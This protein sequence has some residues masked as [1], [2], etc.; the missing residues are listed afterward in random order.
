MRN[1]RR[2]GALLLALVVAVGIL[3]MPVQAVSSV[4]DG[5][6]L[7]LVPDQT[8][9]E[10]GQTITATLT[11]CNN[12]DTPMEG[13]CLQALI[14]QGYEAAEE[15][16]TE[17]GTLQPGEQVSI[18]LTFDPEQLPKMG[19]PTF[20]WALVLTAAAVLLALVLRKGRRGVCVLLA[21]VMT[22]GL[23]PAPA[24]AVGNSKTLS[25]RANVT[26]DGKGLPLEAQV[27]YQPLEAQLDPDGD[28][29][30]TYL[31]ELAKTDPQLADTDGD[32]VTDHQELC[33]IGTDPLVVDSDGDGTPDGQEDA[34][35]DLLDNAREHQLGTQPDRPDT[36]GDGITDG[37]E[38][39]RCHTDPLRADTD[40]DA[41]DDGQEQA[42]GSDPLVPEASFRVTQTASD[43]K[44]FVDM[45]LTGAQVGTLK[46]EDAATSPLIPAEFPGYLGK[47]YDFTVDGDFRQAQISFCFNE[48]V[49]ERGAKPTIYYVDQ[50]DQVLQP[51]A[52]TVE[53]GVAT[54]TVEHFSTYV[55]L[56]STVY[57]GSFTWEDTWDNTGT[58][59]SVEVVLVVDDSGSM[60]YAGDYLDPE[61]KRLQV[62]RDLID[63][64]PEGAKIG[65]VWFA[66]SA[67]L[68]TPTLTTDKEEAKAW[69]TT[70]YFTSIG[71]STNMY[72]A[73]D[74]SLELFQST[75]ADALKTAIVLTDGRAHDHDDHHESTIAAAQ[76]AGVQV[77]TVGLGDE[78][79]CILDHLQPLSDSTGG[80]FHYAEHAD[81]LSEIYADISKMI[82]L[83]V[84]TDGDTIPDYYEDNMVTF[85]GI[86]V[87]LD[88]NKADTDGD[89]LMDNEEVSVELVYSEDKSQIYVKG[90]LHSSPVLTDSDYDGRDDALDASPLDSSYQGTS[91]SSYA[92]ST[93]SGYMDYRWFFGDQT[94]Y[95]SELCRL[96]ILLAGSI[97]DGSALA[98][99]DATG[100]NATK[101]TTLPMILEYFGMEGARTVFLGDLYSDEHLS[102]VGLGF[103][104]VTVG[105]VTKTV[106][107]VTVR[108]TNATIEEWSSNC[109]IGDISLHTEGDDWSNTLNHKG[110]D[111][112]ATRIMAVVESYI[113]EQGLSEDSLVYWV[114]GHSRGAAIANIIGAA[115]EK[116]GKTAFTYTFATPNCTLDPEAHSYTSIFNLINE[117]DFVP[118]MP[119]EAWGYTTFG[120]STTTQSI[121]E[122]YEKEW[123]SFTGI[124][125]Y[126]S[127]AN[128]M[129][130]CVDAI[131]AILPAGTDPRVEAFRYTCACHGDG[132]DDTITITNNGMSED[133]REKA[134]AKIPENALPVCII[135]RYE[136][137]WISGWN[138]DVCQTPSYLMQLLAAFMGGKIDTYRFVME[139]DIA[140]RYEN[141]KTAISAAGLSGIEHPH[142][143]ESYYVLAMNVTEADF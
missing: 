100:D 132:S 89:G 47:A 63:A 106:V 6:E 115:Y 99:Q 136:G 76:A 55:L 117:D 68:L 81:A 75:E 64:L 21:L 85:S 37:L 102:E 40:G 13:V 125:D 14:P 2:I 108:G 95:N 93:V 42:L 77:H 123:E 69:L 8:V 135:T 94:V 91:T 9:Y 23:L 128:N 72:Q 10:A 62:A 103:R 138:F 45:D 104:D 5:L 96:S 131:A 143:P 130:A 140:K 82:D 46:V 141:A 48:Q 31:E 109:D 29:L 122:M 71:G 11:V 7:E 116:A 15:I 92:T 111:I 16:S 58:Y 84:D 112:A 139:L 44:A 124:G 98:L 50:D 80:S 127:D 126:N 70:R 79:M 88:K 110:F 97:Y 30:P 57:Q 33:R 87:A 101:G 66:S 32:G 18:A 134:I 52:T 137:G 49:L 12:N 22:V 113:Q 118:C 41:V 26:V 39:L 73:I 90:V 34:D 3:A 121:R 24:Q 133:S 65:V 59:S 120:R 142:Y 61:N 119:M 129:Q 105:G 114:T 35:R 54:A 4:C 1:M 53:G 43:G 19:D 28:G 74:K 107:N 25:V 86:E 27:R 36:D 38:V 67:K 56:D 60:G 51:L 83:S 20:P 17:P 78:D